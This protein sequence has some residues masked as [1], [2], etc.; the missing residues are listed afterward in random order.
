[1]ANYGIVI[2][3]MASL[4]EEIY[5]YFIDYFDDPVMM[6]I[7]DQDNKFSVY[8]IKAYCL[9]SK[10]C[11]FIVCIT[12]IDRDKIGKKKYLSD[13]FW[14]SL[15]TRTLPSDYYNVETHGYTPVA[16]GP[17]LAKIERIKITKEASTYKCNDIP[18]MVTLLHTDKK[19]ADVYQ[20]NGTVIAAIETWETIIT[21]TNSI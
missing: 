12:H 18:I 2:D 16:Q 17:L 1:M 3:D 21:F 11:R 5:D 19:N 6:K 20:N 8:G 10:E 9:L 14:I 7:K 4:N 13:L 15:Q